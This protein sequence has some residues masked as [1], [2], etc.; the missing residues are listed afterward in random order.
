M[1][2]FTEGG[3]V[4]YQIRNFESHFGDRTLRAKSLEIHLDKDLYQQLGAKAKPNRVPKGKKWDAQIAGSLGLE[5]KP[6]LVRSL[7]MEGGVEVFF[8]DMRVSCSQLVFN[9]ETGMSNLENADLQLPLGS[10][11]RG[12][13]IRLLCKNMQESPDGVIIASDASLT[14]C[15][16]V[17]P[18]YSLSL[19]ELKGVPSQDGK[20]LWRPTGAWLN[21][22]GWTF[23]PLPAP[24]IRSEG[25]DQ[26]TFIGFQDLKL[27]SG[28]R[29]GE[30]ATVRFGSSG[31]SQNDRYAYSWSAAPSWS[32]SRGFPLESSAEFVGDNI[33]SNW[34]FFF[35]N[36][37]GSDSHPFSR[38]IRRPS[39]E[40]WMVDL[41][42]RFQLGDEW[43]ADLDFVVAS[44]P[45]LAPEFFHQSWISGADAQ[46]QLYAIRKRNS[47]VIDLDF[48]IIVDK[49]G[50]APLSGYSSGSD[51]PTFHEHLP[52]LRYH[53]FSK[54]V[55]NL[56][57]TNSIPVNLSWGA[58]L[59]RERLRQ[60]SVLAANGS[61]AFDPATTT[62]RSRLHLWSEL[63][64]PFHWGA[65]TFR[66]GLRVDSTHYDQSVLGN[67]R[68]TR[69]LGEA[70]IGGSAL[71]QQNY[72][73]GWEHRVVP[74][75][76]FRTRGE[77]GDPLALVPQFDSVDAATK[78]SVVEL[79][80]R[81]FF[82]AP[83][84]SEPWVDVDFMVPWYPDIDRPLFDPLFPHQRSGITTDHWGPAEL[85]LAW[86]PRAQARNALAPLIADLRLRHDFG[87]ERPEEIFSR[88][89]VR[90]GENLHYGVSHQRA[91]NLFGYTNVWTDWR[92]TE[93]LG[94]LMELPLNS[95]D[96]VGRRSQAVFSWFAHDFVFDFGA[97]R[98]ISIGET[99]L[100]FNLSPRF[101]V[102]SAPAPLR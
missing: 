2:S 58:S 8:G 6:G 88:V 55:G 85:R 65:V 63:V 92:L 32:S 57:G 27:G 81:Q 24:D 87:E 75:L 34:S 98:D 46:S 77:S 96:G 64:T 70:F 16:A 25:L 14:T 67:A 66:P 19:K 3:E 72:E 91:E 36:D 74:E 37:S 51:G 29:L 31:R 101:L 5:D 22:Y 99:A 13:P 62:S 60:F 102:D 76:R 94:F 89:G 17:P 80:L 84:S 40:R 28:G 83:N 44:D 47:S 49:Y 53:A 21:M 82:I 43:R 30:S 33:H 26:N 61:P 90:N 100:F 79:S 86:R 1:H 12:W 9:A 69:G 18:H 42:N 97:K 11:P 73:G 48:D 15:D 41:Q 39:D 7:F 10:G 54:T 78:G 68:I 38:R 50:Y 45:L 95:G 20:Y 23:L 93:S 4:V 52:A 59:A 71:L 35:L 56:P